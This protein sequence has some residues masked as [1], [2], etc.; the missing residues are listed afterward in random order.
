M[1]EGRHE[2]LHY[3]CVTYYGT[4]STF[5]SENHFIFWIFILLEMI[6]FLYKNVDRLIKY[7][8]LLNV[9]FITFLLVVTI[10]EREYSFRGLEFADNLSFVGVFL[11]LLFNTS[12]RIIYTAI[13]FIVNQFLWVKALKMKDNKM[14]L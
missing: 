11:N 14:S 12:D 8:L 10:M 13:F 7:N 6:L 3:I 9:F 4:N 1:I 2:F 5:L